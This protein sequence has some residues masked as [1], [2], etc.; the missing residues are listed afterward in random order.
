MG[1]PDSKASEEKNKLE[2]SEVLSKR[3][4]DRTKNRLRKTLSNHKYINK[5]VLF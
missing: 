2:L 1:L 4:D 5:N 3:N